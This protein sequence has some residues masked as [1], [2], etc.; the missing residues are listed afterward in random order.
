MKKFYTTAVYLILFVSYSYS[1]APEIVDQQCYGDP[2]NNYYQTIEETDNG[3]LLGIGISSGENVT[4]YHGLGDIWIISADSA[5]NMI[6]ERCYGGSNSEIPRKIIRINN[7][8]YYVF[9]SS[10]STD[11]DVQSAT[12]DDGNLWVIKI[13]EMG[14]ILWE[15]SYGSVGY[16]EARDLILCPDGGFVMIARIYFGGGDVS[17]V[18]GSYDVWMC[19]C[20]SNGN[21][22]WETTLG[23]DGSDNGATMLINSENNIMMIGATQKHGGVVECYP[24][25]VWRDVWLVELDLQGNIISQHCYGGSDYDLGFNIVELNNGYVLSCYTCSNDGDVSGLHGPSGGPPNGWN[26]IWLVRLG[27]QFEIAWQ[28]CLG[29]YNSDYPA[30]LTKTNNENIIIMG[31]TGSNDGDVSGNHSW[32]G[33]VDTDIWAVKLSPDGELIWQQCYGGLG[34]EG[35]VSPHTII[36]KTDHNFLITS[37]FDFGPSYDVTCSNNSP[38]KDDVWLFEIKDCSQY[39]PSIPLAPSGPDTVCSASNQQDIYTTSPASLAWNYNW[40]I[41]PETAGSIANDSLQTTVTWSAAY[42]GTATIIVRSSNDCGFSEWSQPHYTQVYSCLEARE[43]QSG[44]LKVYPNPAWDYV[45]FEFPSTDIT[46]PSAVF[47]MNVFGQEVAN[48]PVNS[49]QTVWDCS[50]AKDGIYYYTL[51]LE[52]NTWSGKL[53]V[54]H[55]K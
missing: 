39:S 16:D 25:E 14:N 13:D 48:L 55:L 32:P 2:E 15:N 50:S 18:Y 1:Q 37:S 11:G 20:D 21:I 23:N 8:E 31:N 17:N 49:E 35:I 19:K 40:K 27:E 4:N 12:N 26:D 24:D 44:R 38:N 6:W 29:G 42:E 53:I 3:Y 54:N 22:E 46:N 5:H 41:L 28:K 10:Y 47:V 52:Q 43:L 7:S 36:K 33:G 30:Y 45:V 51:V 9:G 34:R